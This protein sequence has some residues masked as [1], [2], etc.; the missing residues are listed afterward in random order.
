MLMELCLNPGSDAASR[1]LQY[2][3]HRINL[4]RHY[5]ITP[6]VVF[7]GGD[8]PCKSATQDERQRQNHFAFGKKYANLALAKDKLAE[9]NTSAAIDFFQ[10]RAGCKL[11]LHLPQGSSFHLPALHLDK[12]RCVSTLVCTPYARSRQVHPVLKCFPLKVPQ[13]KQVFWAFLDNEWNLEGKKTER[14]FGVEDPRKKALES[15][16]KPGTS[17]KMQNP[18][19][20]L[21]SNDA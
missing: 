2:F 13:Q 7:D 21:N 10:I 5:Q 3:M 17:A 20:S 11:P 15:C 14:D 19:T 16:W 12:G 8:I 18:K 9:G 1:Y 6:V 4:L